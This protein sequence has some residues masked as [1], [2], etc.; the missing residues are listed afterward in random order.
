MTDTRYLTL[1]CV[2]CLKEFEFVHNRDLCPHC[3]SGWLRP[4]FD[5]ERL[6]ARAGEI[7][8]G[9]IGC[10]WKYFDLLPIRDRANIVSMGEGGT[11]LIRSRMSEQLGIELYLKDEGAKPPTY[12]FKDRGATLAISALKE[13]GIEEVVVYSTGNIGVAYS[14]YCQAAGI[15]VHVFSPRDVEDEKRELIESFG[16]KLHLVDGTYDESKQA[17]KD[18]SA[19]KGIFLDRGVM[20]FY[21]IA[22]KKTVGFEVFEQL[23]MRAPDWIFQAVS[24]GIGPMGLWVAFTELNHLRLMQGWPR[25]GCVQATG[26]DPMYQ[27]FM[28]DSREITNVAAPTTSI[29][30]IATGYPVAY[31]HLYNVVK[32]S[33]GTFATVEDREAYAMREMLA[34]DGVQAGAAGAAAI[35][36]IKKLAEQ[37]FFTPGQRVVGIV[38]GRR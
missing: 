35:A 25:I 11:P 7:F 14:C 28:R 21:R 10:L 5:Y 12:T 20:S 24:G 31:P 1:E 3:G 30:T 33:E 17:A 38:T 23:G 32:K 6:A 19:A 4:V 34:D 8:D 2:D 15:T 18:Y 36:G 29:L 26:C 9:R 22:S 13:A 16:A 27:S 37:G